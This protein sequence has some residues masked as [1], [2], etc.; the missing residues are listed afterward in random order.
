MMFSCSAGSKGS[1]ADKSFSIYL[2]L[3]LSDG[4]EIKIEEG[5]HEGF[6]SGYR[7]VLEKNHY[8]LSIK[9]EGLPS[10]QECIEFIEKLKIAI[11]WLI[12][13]RTTGVRFPNELNEI[14]FY[15][16]PIT[17]SD[18]SDFKG[19]A[20]IAGW[21][22]V[23]GD[24]YANQLVIIQEKKRL[25]KFE[26]GKLIVKSIY[27]PS[28]IL[29]DFNECLSSVAIDRI[30]Q[31]KK[32]QVA[33][34]LF[35]AY[36]FE[37]TTTGKFVK[38]VTVI[39]ALLPEE[40]VS[41]NSIEALSKAKKSIKSYKNSLKTSGEETDDI[42][43]LLSRI[44]NLKYRSIGA[45]LEEYMKKILEQHTN[46][47]DPSTIIPKIRKIYSARSTLLHT[48]EYDE[49]L[50]TEYLSILSELI[51]KILKANFGFIE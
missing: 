11:S 16:S 4:N 6:L 29:E 38:L 5:K 1:E 20:D 30:S 14:C 36:K 23:D 17:V 13:K 12:I 2:P 19:L 50:I 21:K 37:N 35:S 45:N 51:P 15:K 34:D 44:G 10:R 47:G 42:D 8:Q 7:C 24:Y 46:L 25:V 41:L 18:K 48:G 49:K 40:E 22:E 32:L 33:V 39:E 26:M 27:Q 43:H 28:N 3:E 9:I 31:N